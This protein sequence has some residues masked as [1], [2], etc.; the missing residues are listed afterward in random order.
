MTPEGKVKRNVRH[1]LDTLKPDLSYYMPSGEGIA[2]FVINAGG[3]YVEIETKSVYTRYRLSG[4]QRYHAMEI[5]NAN[6]IYWVIDET[7]DLSL[8]ADELHKLVYKR[9]K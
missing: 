4:R 6:G 8:L 9:R 5:L 2:D 1:M 7:I 3:T